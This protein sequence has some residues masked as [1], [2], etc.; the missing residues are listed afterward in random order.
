MFKFAKHVF[1]GFLITTIIPLFLMFFW[2]HHQM[3]KMIKAD[4][5]RIISAKTTELKSKTEQYLKIREGNILE[6][7]NRGYS[8]Q[9]SSAELAN[10]LRA[11]KIEFLHDQNV[12]RLTSYYKVIQNNTMGRPEL[13]SVCTL[14]LKGKTFNGVKVIEKADIN[15]F[16]PAGPF[17][18]AIYYGDRA[19][20]KTYRD[21]VREKP[22]PPP[23]EAQHAPQMG[24]NRDF[25]PMGPPPEEFQARKFHDNY[26]NYKF[27][28]QAP[29]VSLTG[30]DGK[31]VTTM[32]LL[33]ARMPRPFK[34]FL[35]IDNLFGLVVLLAGVAL[36][37][38]MG[39][40]V[41]ENFVNPLVAISESL[42]KVKNGDL[43]TELSTKKIKQKNVLDTYHNFNKMIKELK[44]KEQLR[45]S[46]ISNLTHDLRTPLI[47]QE[48][49]LGLISK[50]FETLDLKDEFELAKS[51]ERSNQHLLRMVNLILESY[52]FDKSNLKLNIEEI[53][54]LKLVE[55]CYETLKPLF[56][57]KEVRFE[58][59]IPKYFNHINGDFTSL[60]RVLLNLISNALE[61]IKEDGLIKVTAKIEGKFT[62]ICVEDNGNGIAEEDL[63]L[64][65]DRYHTGKSFERKLGS[66]LGLDVCKKLIEAH[67]GEIKVESKLNEYTKFTISLPVKIGD[68]A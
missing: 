57:E 59:E 32:T 53:N 9:M 49:S 42:K 7:I 45:K 46:F 23:P 18:L 56:T 43:S 14:P 1:I 12:G 60:K 68:E 38:V 15:Q 19:D 66:G 58:C 33:P 41:D 2:T 28:S 6:K 11:D 20:K 26:N 40:Y 64:I 29:S 44:N 65:F 5:Q 47:A 21:V 24:H 55:G 51:L 48:K 54:L 61:N 62:K 17:D 36:S 30:E 4:Q 37:V 13:Y 10:L 34:N 52:S 25:V 50:K 3:G 35:P 16:K 39:I 8:P 27:D 22:G 31:T 63:P 67:N